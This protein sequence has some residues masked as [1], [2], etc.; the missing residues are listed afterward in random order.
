MAARTPPPLIVD[1]HA[2]LIIP[3][4]P[5]FDRRRSG[6]SLAVWERT[7]YLRSRRGWKRIPRGYVTDWGSIPRVA[8]WAS[9]CTIEPFDDHA[10]AAGGHDWDYAVGE[11][12][13]KH[14][15]D[16]DFLDRMVL[17]DVNAARREVMYRCVDWFGRDG[18]RK[19]PT[20]W[21]S[22]NFADPDTG[23]YPVPP[24]FRR[25]EAFAGGPWGIRPLPDW[26]EP[27]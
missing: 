26:I 20:W 7:V 25:E 18:Y 23:E 22:A 10:I 27:S 1:G 4:R 8:T 24:P 19:A 11:P 17:D 12:G 5:L 14:E 3:A 21:E 15:A 6:R 9:F 2:P 13:L 16:R